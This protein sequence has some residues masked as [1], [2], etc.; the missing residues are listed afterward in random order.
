MS[1]QLK[2]YYQK[3]IL[4]KKELWY[5]ELNE[6]RGDVDGLV[7]NLFSQLKLIYEAYKKMEEGFVEYDRVEFFLK[8]EKLDT[9]FPRKQVKKSGL[10][11]VEYLIDVRWDEMEERDIY[12]IIDINLPGLL[13]RLNQDERNRLRNYSKKEPY[14]LSNGQKIEKFRFETNPVNTARDPLFVKKS[15]Y[16]T[17]VKYRNR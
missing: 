11:P 13:W 15:H 6:R 3:K 16:K 17:P 2:I 8:T 14:M 5:Y 12:K 10:M 7:K 4:R 9:F 1:L